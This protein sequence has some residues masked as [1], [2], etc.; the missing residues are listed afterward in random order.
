MKINEAL[1]D[2]VPRIIYLNLQLFN[3]FIIVKEMASGTSEK[4]QV[5]LSYSSPAEDEFKDQLVKDLKEEKIETATSE[6]IPAEPRETQKQWSQRK[7]KAAVAILIVMSNDY[8]EDEECMADA[9]ASTILQS[10]M[11]FVKAKAFN[12]NDWT[13]K[14][15]GESLSFDLTEKK[16]KKNLKRLIGSLKEVVAKQG[17]KEWL[18]SNLRF[19][20]SIRITRSKKFITVVYTGFRGLG[21]HRQWGGCTFDIGEIKNFA[22]FQTLKA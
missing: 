12:E 15:K 13:K 18:Q 14:L 3:I 7:C 10:P 1:C 2:L 5:Y 16:Y 6:T 17:N 22:F 21:V 9:E 20:T 11:F 8:Q 19:I 4:K